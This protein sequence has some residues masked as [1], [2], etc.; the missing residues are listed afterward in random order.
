MQRRKLII[1]PPPPSSVTAAALSR[2]VQMF[3]EGTHVFCDCS[4]KVKTQPPP[5]GPLCLSPI[6]QSAEENHWPFADELQEARCYFK[7][8]RFAV[9]GR[10]PGATSLAGGV[11]A[12][13]PQ[14][15]ALT[16]LAG[17]PHTAL[18]LALPTQMPR[19]HGT[20][21]ASALP[22]SPWQQEVHPRIFLP[23][24]QTSGV[25]RC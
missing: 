18:L 22:L 21:P 7:I 10:K 4:T 6:S 23:L 19:P 20:S 14:E 17:R 1:S 13:I 15:L 12:G 16:A 5:P 2:W 24:L 9:C 11:N 8:H 3:A 25:I